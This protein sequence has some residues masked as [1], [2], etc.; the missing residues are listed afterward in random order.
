MKNILIVAVAALTANA[1]AGM[2]STLSSDAD[3]LAL[4]LGESFVAETRTGNG[5]SNGDWEI[6]LGVP[7]TASPDKIAQNA[8]G[9]GDTFRFELNV[10]NGETFTFTVDGIVLQHTELASDFDG[11]SIRVAAK[12]KNA[13]STATTQLNDLKLDG[14][15]LGSGSIAGDNNAEYLLYKGLGDS[16]TL[17]GNASFG[18][19]GDFPN[20][21]RASFQI[22]GLE[23][24]IPTP[25][26]LLLGVIGL[27]AITRRR[28]A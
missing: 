11:L 1:F 5:A 28:A 6:G 19:T 4:G 18:W 15:T 8:W 16:F 26:A 13:N 2:T 10:V 7:D 22:K 25:G 12:G 9:N 21:S 14:V 17:T 23:T 3:F 24:V 27:T 20:G